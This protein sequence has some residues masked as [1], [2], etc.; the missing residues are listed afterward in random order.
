MDWTKIGKKLLYP[1]IWVMILL[2]IISASALPMVF[3]KDLDTSP[4]AYIIYVISF[5]TLSVVSIFFGITFP[6]RYREIRKRIYDNPLGNRYMTDA[7]FRTR[8]SLHTSLTINLLYVGFNVFLG[9]W[10]QTRWFAILAGYYAILAVMRFLLVK[11]VNKNGL[12]KNRILEF[13]RSRVCGYILMTVN[14]S[15]SCAVLMILFQNR[16]YE[17]HGILIYVM[18]MYTFY[19]TTHATIDITVRSCPRLRLSVCRQH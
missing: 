15:L 4:I 16:G 8:I 7:A 6:K 19:V 17:Y 3:I 2:T 10:H 5:Y 13:Q 18:A 14:V 1:P 11:F 9:V 12:G